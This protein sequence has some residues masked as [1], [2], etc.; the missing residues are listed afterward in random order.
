[1]AW[2]LLLSML[3]VFAGWFVSRDL[4]WFWSYAALCALGLVGLCVI[5]GDSPHGQI[6]PFLYSLPAGLGAFIQ[7]M[8]LIGVEL[9]EEGRG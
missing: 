4:I 2:L 8:R 6:A 9:R 5:L 7:C 1:M 3:A